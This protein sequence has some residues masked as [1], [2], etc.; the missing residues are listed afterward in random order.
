MSMRARQKMRPD[1]KSRKENDKISN[2]GFFHLSESDIV[3]SVFLDFYS[4]GINFINSVLE[5]QNP[6]NLVDFK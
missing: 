3:L 5:A 4:V 2:I 1:G 6:R